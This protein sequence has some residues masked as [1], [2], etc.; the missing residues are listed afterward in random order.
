MSKKGNR[1]KNKRK[2]AICA[3][4]EVDKLLNGLRKVLDLLEP[5]PAFRVYDRRGIQAELRYCSSGALSA[6]L[7]DWVF[8]LTKRNVAEYY[9]ACPGWGWNDKKKRRE[10]RDTDARYIVATALTKTAAPLEGQ[11]S[12]R[13]LPLAFVH[14]RFELNDNDPVMY[15]YEIQVESAAQGCGLGRFMMQLAELAARRA[16]LTAIML[17]VFKA[18]GAANALYSKLGYTLHPDSPGIHDPLGQHGYE[19]LSKRFNLT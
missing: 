7:E 14:L 17:T 16:G 13:S 12:L 4:T 15:I 3:A 2:D 19:I 6:Q 8:N 9:D 5:F 18:N 11:G 10:L 1:G